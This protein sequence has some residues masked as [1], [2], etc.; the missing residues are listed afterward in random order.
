[1]GYDLRSFVDDLKK[2]GE[3]VEINDETDWNFEIPAYDVISGRFNGPALLFNNVKGCFPGSRALVGHFSGTFQ[4]PHKRCAVAF[5][6]DPTI[7]RPGWFREL[8]PRMKSMLRPVQVA[9]G[10]CKEVILKGKEIN[11]LE[12]PFTYHAIGDGGRY[13]FSAATTIKDPDSAWIN[14]GQY[15]IEVYSRNRLVITPYAHSNF[16]AIYANKYEARGESMP[17]AIALGGDPAISLSAG[18]MLPPGVTEFDLAGGLR[19]AP[20]ELIKAETSDLLVPAHAEVIIEGEIRPY[21]R[22]PEGPKIE[23]FGFSTGPRQPFFAIRV[24]CITHRKNPIIPDI[25]TALCAGADSLQETLHPYAH[26]VQVRMLGLPMR[27]GSAGAP[28]RSGATGRNPV[29]KKKLPE[30]Y[31]GFMQDVINKVMGQPGLGGVFAAQAFYDHDVNHLDFGDIDE[32]LFSQTT[33]ARDVIK[34]EFKYPVMTI[35]S[36]WMEEEDREK[37][38]GPGVL[39]GN[40]LTI[41]A[42]TKEEPPM[43]VRRLAFESMFPRETQDWVLQNW[44][45]LGFTEETRTS[46]SWNEADL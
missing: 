29:I 40:K 5:G 42:T 7:D 45:R 30:D 14:T 11:L 43:G 32:A 37:F 15:A 6:I 1:M 18:M 19:G 9:S 21:E 4:K 2:A 38:V 13:I 35:E 17:V 31:P 8:A 12:F 33:P 44:E 22:L 34:I 39:L 25:H 41:D 26:F 10:P 24:H 27:L 23:T 16:R 46:W 28:I 20:I 3:L 36:S